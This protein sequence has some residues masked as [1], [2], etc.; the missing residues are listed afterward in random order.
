MTKDDNII[1]DFKALKNHLESYCYDMRNSV[2]ADGNMKEFIDPS[3][4]GPFLKSID[5]TV[6]WIYGEGESASK[7]I[8]EKKLNDMKEIGMKV[9][10]RFNF[11]TELPVLLQ[12]FQNFGETINQKFSEIQHL[13]DEDRDCILKMHS[14]TTQWMETMQNAVKGKKKHEESGY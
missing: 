8:Y 14:E 2:N 12:Q 9:K 1:L 5:E 3:V 10:E 13:T 11:H 4:V 6:D 7:D